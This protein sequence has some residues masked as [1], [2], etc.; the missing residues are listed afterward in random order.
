MTVVGALGGFPAP[1]SLHGEGNIFLTTSSRS[2]NMNDAHIPSTLLPSYHDNWN[3]LMAVKYLEAPVG[4]YYE[5]LYIPG[6]FRFSSD[7]ARHGSITS[8]FV[9]SQDSVEWGQRNW[10]IPKQLAN[11]SVRRQADGSER[12][13]LRNVSSVREEPFAAFT[14]SAGNGTGFPVSLKAS[15]S[16]LPIVGHLLELGQLW[17]GKEYLFS[18]PANGTAH[19]AQMSELT[20][21]PLYFPDM[22]LRKVHAGTRVANFSMVFPVAHVAPMVAPGLLEASSEKPGILG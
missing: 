6:T 1:W 10:G 4:P 9:S 2:E 20:F 18:P 16:S 15:W 22:A 11:F 12:W 13:E 14:V 21:D 19:D 17:E 5:L 8:I 7:R 3:L